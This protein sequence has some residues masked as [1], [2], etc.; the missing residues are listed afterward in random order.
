MSLAIVGV[1]RSAVQLAVILDFG[2][3]V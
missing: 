2:C 1:M 3:K